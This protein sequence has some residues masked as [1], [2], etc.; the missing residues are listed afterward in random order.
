M[1]SSYIATRTQAYPKP[2]PLTIP[3]ITRSCDRVRDL[4]ITQNQNQ[5][6]R[7]RVSLSSYLARAREEVL[8]GCKCVG[9]DRA[10]HETRAMG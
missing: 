8:V 5:A 7:S 2:R 1:R 10:V 9:R 4:I 3:A 6:A